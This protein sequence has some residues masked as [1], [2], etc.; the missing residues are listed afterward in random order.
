MT[1][2]LAPANIKKAGPIY[3]LPICIGLLAS[4]QQLKA[5]LSDYAFIGEIALSGE[6]R[7]IDGAL[8]MA[9]T[10]AECGIKHL[11]LP[12]E[13]AKEAAVVKNI[14][15]FGAANLLD[16][17]KHFT[18]E[19]KLTK[20]TIDTDALFAQQTETAMDFAEVKG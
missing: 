10:A 7:P 6:L 18:T 4:S 17:I 13:N 5:D 15:V 20:T 3:D 8:P 11:I 14:D 1:V 16:I 19:E 2:N 9:I 12:A